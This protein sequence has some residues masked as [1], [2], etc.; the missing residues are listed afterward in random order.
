MVSHSDSKALFLDFATI[1]LSGFDLKA[2]L[3][4]F[5]LLSA[6]LIL[7]SVSLLSFCYLLQVGFNISVNNRH[8]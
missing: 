8:K 4:A 2:L 6:I 1:M 3:Q 5:A 7:F